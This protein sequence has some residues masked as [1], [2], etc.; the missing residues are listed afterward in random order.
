MMS[1]CLSPVE[2]DTEMH[3]IIYKGIGSSVFSCNTSSG[4]SGEIDRRSFP[5]IDPHVP[6]LTLRIQC[7]EAALQF[8]ENATFVIL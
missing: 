2:I 1:P 3:Y 8:A 5:F 7:S 6:A 4:T